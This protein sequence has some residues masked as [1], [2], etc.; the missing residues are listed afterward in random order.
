MKK[1]PLHPVIYEINTWI[2]R[3]KDVLS[4]EIYDRSGEWDF[5]QAEQQRCLGLL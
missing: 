2:W 3:L 5:Q 4:G 1:W